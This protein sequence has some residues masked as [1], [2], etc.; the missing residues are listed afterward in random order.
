MMKLPKSILW[1]NHEITV[2]RSNLATIL[3][4]RQ[5]G[6]L[7]RYQGVRMNVVGAILS[8]MTDSEIAKQVDIGKDF[9]CGYRPGI[10][11]DEGLFDFAADKTRL[12][13]IYREFARQVLVDG[14]KVSSIDASW[15][16]K[17][18]VDQ[19]CI[20]MCRQIA[21]IDNYRINAV[22]NVVEKFNKLSLSS[23]YDGTHVF[24]A[25]T[26]LPLKTINAYL[27]GDVVPDFSLAGYSSLLLNLPSKDV[28]AIYELFEMTAEKIKLLDDQY[29]FDTSSGTKSKIDL[30]SDGVVFKVKEFLSPCASSGFKFADIYTIKSILI[31]IDNFILNAD[32]AIK[33]DKFVF[34]Y[35]GSLIG[36]FYALNT[37]IKNGVSLFNMSQSYGKEHGKNETALYKRYVRK[38]GKLS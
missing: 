34:T 19:A 1:D 36:S 22:V 6:Q 3:G 24:A 23:A 11:S 18:A 20:S 27:S 4:M 5:I 33:G 9:V 7:D 14:V 38:F 30:I 26:G 12:S 31:D 35:K 17:Q 13:P 32:E 29:W 16:V 8:T 37:L 21:S 10:I 25:L 2:S 28:R 15:P